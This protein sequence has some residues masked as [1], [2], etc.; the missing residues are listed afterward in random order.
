MTSVYSCRC[1][2]YVEARRIGLI[3][4]AR[5]RPAVAQFFK[6]QNCACKNGSREPYPPPLGVICHTLGLVTIN[7][8]AKFE[9]LSSLVTA[10]RK[11]MP[12]V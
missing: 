7:V 8:Y 12:N 11:A 3:V 2:K 10:T 6:L 5:G 1:D 4:N 9:F